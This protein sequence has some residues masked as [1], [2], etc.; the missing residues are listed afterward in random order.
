MLSWKEL[1]GRLAKGELA[2][3]SEA[4]G[5]T[6]TAD[7]VAAFEAMGTRRPWDKQRRPDDA[8]ILEFL[9]AT[10]REAGGL[11]VGR[12][13]VVGLGRTHVHWLGVRWSAKGKTYL[14]AGWREF[15]GSSMITAC[16]P[17]LEG[18]SRDPAK[19]L[20]IATRWA[21]QA[22]K[23]R[24]TLEVTREAEAGAPAEEQRLRAAIVDE[25]EGTA[26]RQV[27]ADWLIER[28]RPLGELI[29][30]SL[31]PGDHKAKIKALEDRL[32]NE[33]GDLTKYTTPFKFKGGFVDEVKM[34][35]P[36]FEKHGEAFFRAHPIRTLDLVWE[37]LT[38][39][40]LE[41]FARI[42]AVA[43]VRC[44][45]LELGVF[46][47]KKLPLAG[48]GG[49]DFARLEE[50]Q[51]AEVGETAADWR[52]LFS[53]L[54]APRLRK[55]AMRGTRTSPSVYAGLGE[56]PHLVA[57]EEIIERADPCLERSPDWKT[58]FTALAANRPSL[59][60]LEVGRS[61]SMT[62]EDLGVLFAKKS[63]VSL[64]ELSLHGVGTGDAL[65]ETIAA[66]PRADKL[67]S[68]WVGYTDATT[69]GFETVLRSKVP[70]RFLG[71]G[72]A[73]ERKKEMERL[74]E[75]LLALP[76]KHPLE[77]LNVGDFEIPP[78]LSA[79]FKFRRR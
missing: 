74:F 77:R 40:Q 46:T 37:T 9:D 15:F 79:R 61:R 10:L 24:V 23:D 12:E 44:L 31:A 70:L 67:T 69:A 4:L 3:V 63:K 30:L 49:A 76:K 59:R 71:V 11:R 29:R 42:P 50:L 66:S 27:Y 14:T 39:A 2:L 53:R 35:V 38:P 62:D 36:A 13:K 45:K 17:E 72:M 75:V 68:L 48:L 55:L 78:E 33:L 18:W 64:Q 20:I 65:L 21:Q 25:P 34:N 56:N 52:A 19:N 58:A 43:R 26:A 5:I 54:K 28:G 32:W 7:A 47:K 60:R 51:L 8:A 16:W 41:R 1:A 22:A 73:R 57:L 6:L